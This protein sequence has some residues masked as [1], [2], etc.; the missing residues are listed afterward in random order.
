MRT[1]NAVTTLLPLA[2]GRGVRAYEIALVVAVVIPVV[3]AAVGWVPFAL[4]AAAAAVPVV[5]TIYLYDVNE[6]E[7]EPIPVVV[8]TLGAGAALGALAALF[9]DRVLLG[10]AG[11]LGLGPDGGDDARRSSCSA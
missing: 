1:P 2:S 9:V 4:V 6:W 5:F 3:A 8:A 11:E 10:P 7:D